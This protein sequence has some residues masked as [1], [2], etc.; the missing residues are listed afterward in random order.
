MGQG[1]CILAPAGI[2][3][4]PSEVTFFREAD[5]WGFILFARNIDTPDQVRKLTSG[6]REAVGRN[7]TVFI[8]QEGGRVQRMGPPHWRQWLPPL[9]DVSR[10]APDQIERL[11]ALRY[12][13]ISAELLDIGINGNC[14]PCADIATPGTHPFLKNRCFGSDKDTVIKATKAVVE[15]L[16][17]AGV[18]P[19]IKHIPGH[20]RATVDSHAQVPRVKADKGTLE[21]TD[22]SVFK[23]LAHAPAGMTCHCVYEAYDDSPATQS[24]VMIDLVRRSMGFEGLLMTD[25]I[26]MG[27]LSGNVAERTRAAIAAGCDLVLHC[28]GEMAEMVPVAEHCG[29]LTGQAEDRA[30]DALSA[31]INRS[32]THG[33][34]DVAALVAA[35]E[36]I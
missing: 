5:P 27:A 30:K 14:V 24:S 11:V 33:D 8:D 31:Q 36:Q 13:I 20:G 23:S 10:V 2:H 29:A 34:I 19:V 25:D 18:L 1:A 21:S 3:L 35:Y 12:K 4:T 17:G 32:A 6:L 7:A 16:L 22:F 9:D 28:N 26:S 15:T